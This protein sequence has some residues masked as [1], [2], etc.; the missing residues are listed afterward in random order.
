MVEPDL[1]SNRGRE[2]GLTRG[3]CDKKVVTAVNAQLQSMETYINPNVESA[4]GLRTHNPDI[5]DQNVSPSGSHHNNNQRSDFQL[6][7]VALIQPVTAGI[8]FC[9]IRRDRFP[10]LET[11]SVNMEPVSTMLSFEDLTLMEAIIARWSPRKANANSLPIQGSSSHL[12]LARMPTEVASQPSYET[13]EVIDGE[14]KNLSYDVTFQ[15]SRLGLV[16]KKASGDI[17]VERLQNA[18]EAESVQAGD[19]LTT[20]NGISVESAS[21]DEVVDRLASAQRPVKISFTR[22]VSTYS[23]ACHSSP[24]IGMA[25][26]FASLGRNQSVSEGSIDA[27]ANEGFADDKSLPDVYTVTLRRG[28]LNGVTVEPSPCGSLPVVIDVLP[29]FFLDAISVVEGE[30]GSLE[31]KG[32]QYTR[33][34]RTGAVVTNINGK[35]TCEVG[36]LKTKELLDVLSSK[37][38]DQDELNTVLGGDLTY[39][40]EFL[41]LDSSA[42]GK[43]KAADIGIAGVALTFIDDFK[44]RD[45]PLLRGKLN[46]INVRIERGLGIEPRAIIAAP[47]DVVDLSK[48]GANSQDEITMVRVLCQTE[49][50]YFHPRI[51]VWEPLLEPSNLCFMV[52][53]QVG[54]AQR[55]GQLAVEASDRSLDNAEIFKQS[56][57]LAVSPR[58]VGFNLTD[59]AAEVVVRTMKEWRDWRQRTLNRQ[60]VDSQPL[61]PAE[62][63]VDDES[64]SRAA[65]NLTASMFPL[66][67]ASRSDGA[68]TPYEIKKI[69]G[70]FDAS[71]SVHEAR[72]VAAQKAAKAALVFAQ[73][74][75]AG[76]KEKSESSK[77]FV[78]RNRTGMSLSFMQQASA[79]HENGNHGSISATTHRE[80]HQGHLYSP[81]RTTPTFLADGGDARFHMDVISN[82]QHL[83]DEAQNVTRVRA[84]DGRYP[85]LCVILEAVPGV[86]IK[87]LRNLPVFKVGNTIRRLGLQK[88]HSETELALS[89]REEEG[90]IDDA[91]SSVPVVWTVEIEDNRRILTLSSAV[92]VISSGVSLTVD[93][94][95]LLETSKENEREKSTITKVGTAQ[96]GSP[97]YLPLPLALKCERV[98]VF[99]RPGGL[100][101]YNWSNRNILSFTPTQS[102]DSTLSSSVGPSLTNWVWNE[103]FELACTVPCEPSSGDVWESKLQTLWLSCISLPHVGDEIGSKNIKRSRN[104]QSALGGKSA[105][106]S[107]AIDAG[108]TIRNMLPV[109]LQWEVSAFGSSGIV[110]LDSSLARE[111]HNADSHPFIRNDY[112]LLSGEGVEILSFR[113]ELMDIRAR[114]RFYSGQ[115]WS[116]WAQVVPCSNKNQSLKVSDALESEENETHITR[117]VNVQLQDEFGVPLTIG[118]RLL[119]K[120]AGEQD[121]D[122]AQCFGYNVIVFAE[123]W[124]RNLTSLPLSF[125]CP[126]AQISKTYGHDNR[127]A[128]EAGIDEAGIINAEAAL[129]EIA[130]IFEFGERGKGV[131]LRD[132]NDSTAISKT[133]LLPYQTADLIFEEVFEYVEVENSTVK[134]RWWASETHE[135]RRQDPLQCKEAGNSWV[136]VDDEWK[137]DCS[138]QSIRSSGGWESCRSLIG[139]KDDFFSLRRTF[140]P[141]HPFRR[142]RWFRRRRASYCAVAKPA[143]LMPGQLYE[144]INAFHQP[145]DDAFSRAQERAKEIQKKKERG[146]QSSS[147]AKT[148]DSVYVNE[149]ATKI[150][151]RCADGQWSTHC[152]VPQT[153]Q[154][155]GII[156]VPAS[157]WPMLTKL[158]RQQAAE[159]PE[160]LGA[161]ESSELSSFNGKFAHASLSPELY[162]LCY[163]VSDL[164]EDWG[165]LTRT[166]LVTPRLMLRNDSQMLSMEVKQSGAP[167][168]KAVLIEPG[169]V[170]PFFWADFRLPEL[171]SIRPVIDNHEGRRKYRWSGGFDVCTLGMTAIRVRRSRMS[172]SPRKTDPLALKSI[173]SLVEIRPGTGGTG[174][175]ISFKEEDPGGNGSLFRIEN[176]SPFCIWI[177]QDGVLANPSAT[178]EERR[179]RMNQGSQGGNLGSKNASFYPGS[180]FSDEHAETDGDIVEPGNCT[181]FALDVPFRQGKYAGRKAATMAELTRIRVGLA[182]LSS[183]DGVESTKVVSLST[184][185]ESVRLSPAKLSSINAFDIRT[186]LVDLRVLGV[187]TTDGPTRVLRF[188]LV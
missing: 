141:S 23:G 8:E 172:S 59:A 40:V 87:P 46:N 154:V 37:I 30:N 184:V 58:I 64:L 186:H 39:S 180:H 65:N 179:T 9:Q 127:Q 123:L 131:N 76:I 158:S 11:F 74:R 47:P 146:T 95:V 168:E 36:Y 132:E 182:P 130:S 69:T 99:V 116:E 109:N 20:I 96:S 176:L 80:E 107:I 165:E 138:G 62:N 149:G 115:E 29:S 75:G 128:P 50:D 178:L 82:D 72:H 93:V 49:I 185:G 134:R 4:L 88:L 147:S 54:S 94:G 57:A 183:R 151:I 104:A 77:P 84:Y 26:S 133:Y 137:I 167:D 91:E 32:S 117:Q 105:L 112:G 89:T 55:P 144:G 70:S 61:D 43:I 10:T 166:F 135:S 66:S 7:G 139:G 73:K 175:N 102:F 152:V 174:I 103:T 188:W 153:G 45:M 34:P 41:E 125:G 100:G 71:S 155:H 163:K 3:F 56:S 1:S 27:V 13:A 38:T 22:E 140:N 53:W 52:E 42:W 19:T 119:P 92:R 148:G 86:A 164:G 187:V 15:A 114:F 25:N 21:L 44:G 90:S 136:W 162:E 129:I 171:V 150:S 124:L 28:K 142:R 145:V 68:V 79:E 101:E 110:P 108:L 5:F 126:A 118:V 24:S 85:S 51:A 18:K 121:K 160:A 156:R 111:Q 113:P 33:L 81:R 14:V 173:R 181:A 83:N 106:I 157:R 60:E 143:E 48:N 97:F 12:D 177:A 159:L 98:D 35:P 67:P 78:F 122:A 6:L 170:I 169:D 2:C 120:L 16:L 63:R 17:V 161:H 31:V